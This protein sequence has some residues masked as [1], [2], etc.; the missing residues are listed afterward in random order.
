MVIWLSAIC[1]EIAFICCRNMGYTLPLVASNGKS[2][3]TL[4]LCNM[5]YRLFIV[6]WKKMRWDSFITDVSMAWPNYNETKTKDG[7]NILGCPDCDHDTS[8]TNMHDRG[9]FLFWNCKAVSHDMVLKIHTTY[10][11]DAKLH[12]GHPVGWIITSTSC[13]ISI[14]IF[15]KLS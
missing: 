3:E 6:C 14:I 9:T 4:L 5:G 11:P 7:T 2:R 15:V 12:H 13:W 1:T 10:K 8:Y